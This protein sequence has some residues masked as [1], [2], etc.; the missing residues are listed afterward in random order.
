MRLRSLCLPIRLSLA[1]RPLS[2][3]DP[4]SYDV[5][6]LPRAGG[7]VCPAGVGVGAGFEGGIVQGDGEGFRHRSGGIARGRERSQVTLLFREMLMDMDRL[8]VR[9]CG[10]A[11]DCFAVIPTTEVR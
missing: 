11:L 3:K 9:V 6:I 10:L 7:S 5:L 4:A 1:C 2:P 8:Y